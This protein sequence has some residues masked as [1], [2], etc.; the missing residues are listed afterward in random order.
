MIS[1]AFDSEFYKQYD[2]KRGLRDKDGK[3]VLTGLTE[4]SDVVSYEI[5]DGEKVPAE[6]NLYYQGYYG[7]GHAVYTVSEPHKVILKKFAKELS[8]AKGI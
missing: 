7:L 4:I 1:G 3:G 2:I 6:G 8:E 5:K